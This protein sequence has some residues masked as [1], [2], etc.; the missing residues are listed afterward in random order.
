MSNTRKPLAK[1]VKE[2]ID[3]V[4]EILTSNPGGYEMSA[5]ELG[6]TGRKVAAILVERGILERNH[7]CNGKKSR[8]Q[9]VAAMA[10]TKVL[11]GSVTQELADRNREE[12][13]RYY[14][15]LKAK[16]SA[17]NSDNDA[18]EA[19]Q[20]AVD[21]DHSEKVQAEEVETFE[22]EGQSGREYI[23][24]LDAYTIEELWRAIKRRGGRIEGGQLAITTYLD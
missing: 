11:Y 19:V 12:K 3:F 14:G 18:E 17:P 7:A 2:T 8:Y 5:R 23:D 21:E 20:K 4:F 13:K 9:W 24:P 16:T 10:P 22:P 6:Q 15:K 1:T